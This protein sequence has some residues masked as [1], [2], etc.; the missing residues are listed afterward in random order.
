MVLFESVLKTVHT[1]WASTAV[2]PFTT[3][4]PCSCPLIYINRFLLRVWDEKQQNE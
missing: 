2:H 4:L 3:E 1:A